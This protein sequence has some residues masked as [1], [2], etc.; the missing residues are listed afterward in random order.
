MNSPRIP[1][2]PE[3]S[4]PTQLTLLQSMVA[5]WR[6]LSELTRIV[7]FAGAMTIIGVLV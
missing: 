6:S 1:K 2:P 5:G 3:P 7:Y 4:S